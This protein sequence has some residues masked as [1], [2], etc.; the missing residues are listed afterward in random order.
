[1]TKNGQDTVT[2]AKITAKATIGVAIISLL[3]NL[4]LG[5][6]QFIAKPG[7]TNQPETY[8]F[9]VSQK[10]PFEKSPVEI[11]KGDNVE[12]IVPGANST[13]INC[14]VGNTTVV[15]MINHEYQPISVLPVANFCSLV[16]RI[17]PEAAPY[18][19]VGAYTNF[20]ADMDG[21]LSLGVND[22][23]PEKCG[24]QDCFP[25]N[26]GTIFVRVNITRK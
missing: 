19:Q 10:Y 11:H 8:E 4:V 15:G 7:K 12:I 6:W 22:V 26:T 14:G 20:V 1:M 2:V 3:G 21:V 16:G 5:Y 23:T 25:D 9:S 24:I 17:G 13:V 18:F